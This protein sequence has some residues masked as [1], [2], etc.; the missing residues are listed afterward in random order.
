MFRYFMNLET[1]WVL[2]DTDSERKLRKWSNMFDLAGPAQ[3]RLV[4]E[5][6]TLLDK[7]LAQASTPEER[8]RIELF[9]KTYRAAEYLFEFANATFIQALRFLGRV[10]LGIFR[11]IAMSAR[12][13]DRRDD[14]RALVLLAP[15]QFL[16]QRFEPV[17]CHRDLVHRNR[18]FVQMARRQGRSRAGQA[19]KENGP[20]ALASNRS[21][22]NFPQYSSVLPIFTSKESVRRRMGRFF[23][24]FRR[25]STPI[26]L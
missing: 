8:R 2:I 18:P 9:S 11:Q 14:A 13:G 1:L 20:A 12:L 22:L 7:A 15:A 21:Q 25:P 4:K 23:G 19:K 16:L 17:G 26:R 5:C 3:L 6:R 10:I 24:R